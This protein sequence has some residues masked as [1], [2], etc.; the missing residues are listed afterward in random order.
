MQLRFLVD[1]T[2]AGRE[3]TTVQQTSLAFESV[4]FVLQ[5]EG[6]EQESRR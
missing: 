3:A 4:S 5:K 2:P 1:F 6:Y